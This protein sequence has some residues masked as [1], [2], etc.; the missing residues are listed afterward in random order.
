L[1]RGDELA[2]VAR[3][4]DS[5]SGM[6][7]ARS[8]R[9]V[10]GEAGLWVLIFGDLS[11]FTLLFGLYAWYR[12]NEPALF[13]APQ[14]SLNQRIGLINT[15]L[16]LTGSWAA[17]EALAEVRAARP[18]P[19]TLRVNLAML[20]GAGFIAM[21]AVEY[22]AKIKA[23]DL[24]STNDFFMFYYAC[25]GLHLLHV[26][27]GMAALGLFRHLIAH[28]LTPARLALME[29]CGVFWHLV[30]MIWVVLFAVFYLHR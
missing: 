30:D 17:A 11:M 22:D 20:C 23:G 8:G 4:Q 14:A 27:V 2:A 5:A 13:A 29:G 28:P 6:T 18:G 1:D 25:T 26:I 15:F 7:V 24:P 9:R 21:K 12:L 10:P 16:L 19:A 3:G